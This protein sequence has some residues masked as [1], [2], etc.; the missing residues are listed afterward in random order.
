MRVLIIGDSIEENENVGATETFITP[1]F[2]P[3]QIELSA[4]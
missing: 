4:P 2:E 3:P 1:R